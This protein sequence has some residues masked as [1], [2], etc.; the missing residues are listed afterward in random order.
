M[1]VKL[2]KAVLFDNDG[3]LIA[4][5]ALH[6]TAWA[7][8]LGEL[9]LPTA[10]EPIARQ[11]GKT[12]PQIIGALLDLYRPGW[13]PRDYDP[14]ALA[15]RKND[16][17]LTQVPTK[18]QAYPGVRELIEWLKGEGIR[19]AVVTNAKRRELMTSL[20]S[21]ELAPLFDALISRDDVPKPKPDPSP[22]LT[23]AALV[24]VEPE[25][26]LV[27]EDS[28]TGIEAG[29]MARIPSA[30]VT[31][32]FKKHE[33]EQPVAGRP[34]LRPVWVGESIVALHTWLKG[35]PIR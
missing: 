30:G 17:Y 3:V 16:I 13:T 27:V 33:L 10:L 28:L 14:D 26:C 1:A 24:G 23:A 8:L 18:L 20:R 21:L 25:R 34:D 11:V 6:W 12:G 2:P 22:Y 7:A 32:S 29:L 5:E 35:L 4:S 15:L 9:G 19:V 31:T